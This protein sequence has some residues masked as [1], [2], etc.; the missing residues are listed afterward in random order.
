MKILIGCERSGAIRK[1]ML[2]KGHDCISCDLEESDDNSPY[3]YKGDIFDML[4][5]TYW[6]LVILHPPCTHL[7]LSGNRWYGNNHPKRLAAIEWTVKL[8]DDACKHSAK[9]ALENPTSVIFRY[10]KSDKIQYVQ[11]WQ[12]GHGEVKK[13]GF[14]LRNLKPLIPTNIVEGREERIWKMPPS[15]DRA[16]LR[17]VTYAGIAEAICEQWAIKEYKTIS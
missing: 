7:A 12:F 3:H 16:R 14:A 2:E 8:W 1:L 9:V 10:L 5:D 15:H 6:D 11:P 13:T 17:S 4:T